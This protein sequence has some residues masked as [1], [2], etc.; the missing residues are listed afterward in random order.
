[1][2]YTC[3]VRPPT[4][5]SGHQLLKDGGPADHQLFKFILHPAIRE[6]IQRISRQ[7]QIKTKAFCQ[8]TQIL[9]SENCISWE[10]SK[11]K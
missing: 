1:M 6:E 11:D 2:L 4:F 9:S 10:W 5:C 8:F 7:K 3:Y